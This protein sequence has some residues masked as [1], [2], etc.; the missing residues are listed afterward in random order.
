MLNQNNRLGVTFNGNY[1]KQ[2]KLGY[3]HGSVVNIC[4]VYSVK[5]RNIDSPDLT[6]QNGLFGGIKITKDVNTSQCKY[7]GYGICFD[8]K[9]KFSIGNITN[10]KNVLIFGVNTSSS[11]YANNKLN[12]IYVLGRD[13]VQ[14]INGTTL[15]TEKIYQ[16]DFTAPDKKFVLILHYN[17]DN[18]YLFVNGAQELKFKSAISYKDRNLLCL[19]NI[20]SDWS[21]TNSTRTGL[22]VNV[23][24]FDEKA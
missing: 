4:I 12:N 9:G 21:L 8:G 11:I 17:D 1:M 15:N 19:G 7:F 5:N 10:G 23:Y 13:I 2:N 6:V 18:S 14:R 16:Q 24:D 22:Y 20:S 3:A